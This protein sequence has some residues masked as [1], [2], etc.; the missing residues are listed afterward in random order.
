[1][2]I[3]NKVLVIIILVCLTFF[4]LFAI[5]NEF[6]NFIDWSEIGQRILNPANDINP[7]IATLALL[8]IL[9]IS[10]F[11]LILEFYPVRS[12]TA[13]IS[14]SKSGFAMITIDTIEEQIKNT[15]NKL[16]GLE[17]ISVKIDPRSNGIIINMFAKLSGD[18]DLPGK[19]QEITKEASTLASEKL[20]IKVIKTNLTIV[21]LSNKKTP[22]DMVEV[23]TKEKPVPAVKVKDKKVPAGRKKSGEEK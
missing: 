11:L 3:F 10:I 8:F 17:D 15:V 7:Y 6:A 13:S 2:N 19:M 5:V 21:G 23:E 9:I 18:Q 4:C 16:N 20:G 12:R 1:M 22:V 14:S